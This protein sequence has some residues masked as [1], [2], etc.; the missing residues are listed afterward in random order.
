MVFIDEGTSYVR[1]AL[2]QAH[3]PEALYRAVEDHWIDWAGPPDVFV[4]DG[5]RGFSSISFGTWLGRA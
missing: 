4:A 5:E 3:D 2:L 1:A